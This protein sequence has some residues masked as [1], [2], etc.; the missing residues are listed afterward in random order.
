MVVATMAGAG[1]AGASATRRGRVRMKAA[2]P[3][4][5]LSQPRSP[6]IMAASSRLIA[7]PRPE[8]PKRRVMSPS[9]CSKRLNRRSRV[10]ASKP[11]PVSCT[12]KRRPCG[13]AS[14]VRLTKPAAVNLTALDTRLVRICFS[15]TASPWTQMRASGATSTT[16]CSPL[17]RAAAA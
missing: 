2:P 13:P 6:F 16:N 17:S 7:S 14:T 1:T 8:P 10:S 9:A 11:M 5:S 3:P 15:R 12:T 4:G